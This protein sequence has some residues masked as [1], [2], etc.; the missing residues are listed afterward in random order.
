MANAHRQQENSNSD[1]VTA[2][3]VDSRVLRGLFPRARVVSGC[4]DAIKDSAP[5]LF[6]RLNG[7]ARR[8]SGDIDGLCSS[9]SD[10]L[11]TDDPTI[12]MAAARALGHLYDDAQRHGIL[13]PGTFAPAITALSAALTDREPEVRLA[14]LHALRYMGDAASEDLVDR[15]SQATEDVETQV[16]LAAVEVLTRFGPTTPI[17]V[18]RALLYCVLPARLQFL[19]WRAGCPPAVRSSRGRRRRNARP[20][21]GGR[22]GPPVRPALGH[23]SCR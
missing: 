21:R 15:V 4:Y 16:R 22:T 18:V 2:E 7:A 9:L 23:L 5:A 19:S 14:V 17:A 1:P 11:R 10:A 3:P 12:R 6:E 20:L 8:S 13:P